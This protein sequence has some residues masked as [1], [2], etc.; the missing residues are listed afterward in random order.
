MHFVRKA[1]L[2]GEYR[3][4]ITF[5]DGNERLVDLKSHLSGEVFEPLNDLAYF[6]KFR[7]N[8]DLDTVVWENGADFS[9]DFLYE[10]GEPVS[11]ATRAA[12]R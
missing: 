11:E 9:P 5:E 3:L 10:I 12:D 2:A 1:T 8:E 6:Q 4:F 7:V